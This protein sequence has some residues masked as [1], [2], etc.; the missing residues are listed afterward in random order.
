MPAVFGS[1]FFSSDV[2]ET[3][4]C[5]AGARFIDEL[6][7]D[8]LPG[9]PGDSR[10]NYLGLMIQNMEIMIPAPGGAEARSGL[11]PTPAFEGQ[12]IAEYP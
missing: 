2:L 8:D 4:A 9:G 6:K 11:D 7:D 5:E 3:I 10:H 12:S 1:E